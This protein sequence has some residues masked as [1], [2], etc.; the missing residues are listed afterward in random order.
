[1]YDAVSFRDSV[2]I[3]LS[4]KV[5]N[6]GFL[7]S[8]ARIARVGTQYYGDYGNIMRSATT[9]QKSAAGFNNQVVTLGHPQD[10]V[11]SSNSAQYQIGFITNV[12]VAGKWLVGDIVITDKASVDAVLSNKAVEF[13]CGYTA[14]IIAKDGDYLGIHYSYEFDNVVGNHVALVNLARA[15]HDATF[16]DSKSNN[17]PIDR[18]IDMTSKTDKSNETVKVSSEVVTNDMAGSSMPDY[19]SRFKSIEDSISK[20][21]DMMTSMQALSATTKTGG[22]TDSAE[23]ATEEVKAP[24]VK[25]EVKATEEVKANDSVDTIESLKAKIDILETKLAKVSDSKESNLDGQEIAA[26]VEV[27]SIVKPLLVDSVDV[28]YN[29]P[30]TQ[31]RKLYLAQQLPHLKGKISDGADA[32]INGLWDCYYEDSA[33]AESAKVDDTKIDDS[34]VEDTKAT[35]I[36]SE[37]LSLPVIDSAQDSFAEAQDAYM[38]R[39]SKNRG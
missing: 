12:K 25:V 16:I 39:L 15:G 2:Q 8:R 29:L 34:K 19:E 24:E 20:M 26:R 37:V 38:E 30:V 28:D 21:M 36:Y 7:R 31:V 9:L 14:D 32:Y 22:V 1:M 4:K 18:V 35:S 6:Q 33:N 3:K 17:I 10:S 13:S 27:W 5:D 11:D 23:E